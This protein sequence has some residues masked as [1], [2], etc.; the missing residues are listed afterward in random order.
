[1]PVQTLV[2]IGA[3]SLALPLLTWALFSRPD[4]ARRNV[5]ANLQRGIGP[6]VWPLDAAAEKRSK[7]SRRPL[8]LRLNPPG[9]VRRLDRLA[10]RAGRPANWPL[11]RLLAAKLVLAIALAG[12]GLLYVLSTGR[13]VAI[14]LMIGLAVLGYFL[15]EIL[16]YNHAQKRNQTIILELADTLDQ[17]TIGVEAG[18]GF[19]AAMAQAGHNRTGPLAEELVRTLQDIEMGRSR[20]QAY[21]SLANRTGVVELRRF[22][23]AIIQADIHGIPLADVLR[24]Q[25]GEMR[26]KRRQRAEEQAMKIPV[27]VIFPLIL[28]IMP[29]LFIVV[30][31]PAA[32]D[33]MKMFKQ[34]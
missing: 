12:L 17:M 4:R 19:E 28:C 6:A 31:G 2:A 7:A 23:R 16:L 13:P 24:T 9:I 20:R 26:I 18:L 32:M 33:I 22:I 30:M 34:Y 21:E 8:V 3:L 29:V 5:V 25:A 27:K 1:M 10:E 11:E 15:P 14:L